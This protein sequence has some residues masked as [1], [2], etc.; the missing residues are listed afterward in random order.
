MARGSGPRTS[1]A[2]MLTD[3]PAAPAV[4]AGAETLTFL[5]GL[6]HGA[7]PP[8]H[9]V[10]NQFEPGKVLWLPGTDLPG[11]AQ[12]AAELGAKRDTYFS[13]ALQDPELAVRIAQ[14]REDVTAEREQRSPRAVKLEQTR[15]CAESTCGIGGLWWEV[16]VAH[17]V[18]KHQN[19]PP[20]IEAA[21]S[22]LET[23]ALPPSAVV[24]SGHGLHAWW[25]LPEL[26]QWP[27]DHTQ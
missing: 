21:C 25:L 19:L 9:L 20:T 22:L 2:A 10:L 13:C 11:I 24:V 6:Y 16:D 15:G 8:A 5:R 3:Q 14:G 26:W 27:A 18:H 23:L 12:K 7:T 17:A 4:P 1:W